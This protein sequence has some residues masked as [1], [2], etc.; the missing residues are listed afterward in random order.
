MVRDCVRIKQL[1]PRCQKRIKESCVDVLDRIDC[2]DAWEFC[3]RSLAVFMTS[4][5]Y[6]IYSLP[7]RINVCSS[8]VNPYDASR[9]W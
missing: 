3:W 9:P 4:E 5:L 7:P 8:G 6:P 2:N 1:A